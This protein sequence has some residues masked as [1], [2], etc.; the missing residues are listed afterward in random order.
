MSKKTPKKDEMGTVV[1]M[2]KPDDSPDS[3]RIPEEIPTDTSAAP[4]PQPKRNKNEGFFADLRK[5]P[6]ADWGSRYYLYL[7]RTEP[8]IDRLRSGETKYVMRYSEPVDEQKLMMEH[9]SGRYRL[10]LVVLKP[11]G[12]HHSTE[13]GRYECDILN[14]QFPPKI[15]KGEWTDDP[16]NKKWA[17]AK[18]PDPPPAP[19]VVAQ[20]QN[21]SVLD[22]MRVVSEIRKEVKGEEKPSTPP[23]N[24]MA[25]ALGMAKDLL[26]MRA[27]NPMVEILKDELK[28]MR[29]EIAKERDE[30]RKLQADMRTPASKEGGTDPIDSL[31]R[32]ADKLEPLLKKF[33][34]QVTEAAKEV[35]RGRRPGIGELI[36]EQGLPILGNILQPWSQVLA[37]KFMQSQAQNPAQPM[38]GAQPHAPQAI[39]PPAQAG[40]PPAAQPTDQQSRFI[41]FLT[42]P[43]VL[44]SFNSH[45]TDFRNEKEEPNTHGSDFA[46]W[47]LKS[48]GEEPLKAARAMGT[49]NILNLFRNSPAWQIMG[50]H[51]AKL[52]AFL[53]QVLA[54]DPSVMNAQDDEE[55]EE[56]D[57]VTDLTAK[58]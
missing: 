16:R 29:A 14:T 34:P 50:Q 40:Q 21:A 11:D 37:A 58:A 32:A 52:T 41:Q 13:I 38:N 48:G 44:S 35:V 19:A 17:W 43:L 55:E 39:A 51:E 4:A 18:E 5:I 15:P 2:E 22:A 7:Y 47:I 42:Q 3:P 12:A 10:N 25:T 31:V 8:V 24:P 23:E 27:D 56:D 20:Q 36:I 28:D 57:E 1:T 46:Y 53:D 54:Y 49:T 26:Q 30:N 6:L 45:F 33:M 9:G